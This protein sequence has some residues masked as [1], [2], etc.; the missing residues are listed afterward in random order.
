MG[1][2]KK[3]LNGKNPIKLSIPKKRTLKKNNPPKIKK[4]PAVNKIKPA[5]W[6]LVILIALL[7]TGKLFTFL[8]SLSHPI[9][10][11]FS[12]NKKYSWDGRHS[13][14]VVI[15]KKSPV[16]NKPA[17]SLLHLDPLTESMTVFNLSP[18]I[19]IE[20]PEKK[21]SWA[22]GSIY[23]LGQ[24]ENPPKGSVLLKRSIAKLFG[25]PVDGFISVNEN[26][27]KDD[28]R[29][30]IKNWSTKWTGVL[31]FLNQAKTDLTLPETIA[32]FSKVSTVRADK[33][34]FVNLSD[35]NITESKLL[36]DS[37]RVLGVDTVR[38]DLYIRN[39]IKD[40][41]VSSEEGNI[42]IFNGTSYPGLASEASRIITNLGGNVVYTGNTDQPVEKSM[43][44][45]EYDS[46]KAKKNTS[47]ERLTQI[48][49][50]ICLKKRCVS[51]DQKVVNSRAVINIVLG[52][53]F[54]QAWR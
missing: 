39:K 7:L 44:I 13:I 31:S 8:A 34:N 5:V 24:T 32:L 33:L 9:N 42:A 21:G 11:E 40:P 26:S 45:S 15:K 22:L 17:V 54:Y 30:L 20:L 48:F 14:N 12:N 53:D 36:P 37:S 4:N 52:E 38:L 10:P 51:A 18:D 47:L 16:N 19:F 46:Q 28:S 41:L 1:K 27:E 35:T 25:L 50:P 29:Q 6:A 2:D 23:E 43:I 49:A 3:K